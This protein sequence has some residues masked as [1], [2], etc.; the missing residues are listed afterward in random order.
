MLR[1]TVKEKDSGQR[2]TRQGRLTKECIAEL[3]SNWREARS[4]PASHSMLTV[5]RLYQ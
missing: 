4:R 2:W 5:L 3:V 1:I